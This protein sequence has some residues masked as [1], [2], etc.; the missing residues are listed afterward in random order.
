MSDNV[1]FDELL[2]DYFFSK[3]LREATEWSYRK[4]VKT[5]IKFVGVNTTPEQ[6]TSHMVLTWRRKVI[7]DEKLSKIT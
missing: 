3:S 6:V 4:V 1:S 5:F 2:N 7:A